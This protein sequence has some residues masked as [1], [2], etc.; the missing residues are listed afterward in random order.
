MD[1]YKIYAK[2]DVCDNHILVDHFGNGDKCT[3]CGWRQS[4]ESFAHPN[5]AGIRNIPTLNNAIKQFKEGK[6][7]IL[8][9]FEDF[10]DALENYGELEFTYNNTRFGVLL[11]DT[12]NEI[13]LLNLKNNQKQYYSDVKN[14]AQN[15]NIN[16]IYLKTLWNQ[17]TNTD[18]LQET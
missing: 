8:A 17:V 15:A 14:F 7:A 1:T 2:C 18:F 12:S 3:I 11:D 10:I 9:K 6:S 16:G 5:T 4:E 13:I